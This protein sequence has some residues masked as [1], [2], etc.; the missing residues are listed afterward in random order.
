MMK[1]K[2]LILFF[3][4]IWYLNLCIIIE[5]IIRNITNNGIYF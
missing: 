3:L 5:Y 4:S 2:Y 1:L